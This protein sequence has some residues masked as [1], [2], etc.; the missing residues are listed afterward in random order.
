MTLCCVLS[1]MHKIHPVKHR[2]RG[3][4][5]LG[6]RIHLRNYVKEKNQTYLATNT[7]INIGYQ[8]YFS[9]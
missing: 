2:N 6:R 5:G 8:R 4:A 7:R 9:I 3:P 1:S